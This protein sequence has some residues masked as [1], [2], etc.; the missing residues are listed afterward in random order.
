MKKLQLYLSLIAFG[1]LIINS[2]KRT[3]ETFQ[4]DQLTDY[5]QLQS[6][7]YITYRLDSFVIFNFGT[8]GTI[9]SYLAKD[10]IDTIITDN[11]GRPGWRVIRFLSD[12]SGTDS[13]TPAETYV[14]TPTRETIEVV[15]SN[16]RFQKLKLPI[17]N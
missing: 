2:C 13:W 7:K 9:H 3:T 4:S 17:L 14:I 1:I 16:M 10:V 15:E 11:L 5:M 8:Q 12:T 6:G